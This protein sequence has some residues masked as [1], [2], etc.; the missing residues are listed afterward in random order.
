MNESWLKN[1]FNLYK[2]SLFDEKIFNKILDL[3]QDL[4]NTKITGNKTMILGNGGSAAIA[5][6]VSVDCTKNAGIRLVNFNEAD[7]I[8]CLANDYGYENWMAKAIEFYGDDNDLVILISSSGI[9]TDDSA[10]E[11]NPTDLTAGGKLTMKIV[12][13]CIPVNETIEF[14]ATFTKQ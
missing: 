7:L 4:E 5:S 11:F 10:V 13:V 2:K 3:K 8:T 1:Y 14:N 6:H 9:V 12:P